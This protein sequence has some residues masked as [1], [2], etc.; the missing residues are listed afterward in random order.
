M[1][2]VNGVEILTSVDKDD[3][4]WYSF[5]KAQMQNIEYGAVDVRLTMKGNKVV[6]VR[7]T[8]EKTYNMG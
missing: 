7:V 8:N 3:L 4:K 2:K 5:M 6:A 1:S